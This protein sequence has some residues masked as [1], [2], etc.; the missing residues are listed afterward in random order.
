[1][2]PNNFPKGVVFLPLIYYSL[3]YTIG[4]L[5]YRDIF[6]YTVTFVHTH[7]VTPQQV[8]ERVCDQFGLLYRDPLPV[9][10]HYYPLIITQPWI[11]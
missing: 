10:P 9:S 8:K 6:A 3:M 5:G 2:Q 7:F 1:M 11:I 4:A